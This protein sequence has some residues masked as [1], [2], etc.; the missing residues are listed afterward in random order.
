[1][2][3]TDTSEVTKFIE[4]SAN[5]GSWSE[6][7]PVQSHFLDTNTLRY[8]TLPRSL[9]VVNDLVSRRLADVSCRIP[10]YLGGDDWVA[11]ACIQ[12]LT[13]H[14]ENPQ[15]AMHSRSRHGRVSWSTQ[16][17]QQQKQPPPPKFF[18]RRLNTY[19]PL[20]GIHMKGTSPLSQHSSG[21]STETH[22]QKKLQPEHIFGC[23]WNYQ[24]WRSHS[25]YIVRN[26]CIYIYK[27]IGVLRD[28]IWITDASK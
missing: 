26:M 8:I 12:P 16:I 24:F 15:T 27:H 3:I 6:S 20:A 28:F 13:V 11:D 4:N 5:N 1:M 21:R 10:P 18:P 25:L 14:W 9:L 2:D 17:V 22:Q 19:S 23:N 7:D